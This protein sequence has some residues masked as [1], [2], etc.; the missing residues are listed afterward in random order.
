M[1]PKQ[2]GPKLRR[3]GPITQC[4]IG[5][6]RLWYGTVCLMQPTVPIIY[7]LTFDTMRY[8]FLYYMSINTSTVP[9]D[10]TR[11]TGQYLNSTTWLLAERHLSY[12]SYR[13]WIRAYFILR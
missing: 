5:L 3:A 12:D 9:I 10:L 11:F 7:A 2:F 13:V 4:N 1:K 8:L 6:V